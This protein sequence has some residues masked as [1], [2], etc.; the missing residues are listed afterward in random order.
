MASESRQ[1][2]ADGVHFVYFGD[3]MCSWCYG[4]A[5]IMKAVAQHFADRVPLKVVLGGLRAGNTQ[6]M[7]DQDRDY[8]RNAWTRVHEAS[9]QP[10]DFS[11][12]DRES[13]TYDTEPAC[14]AVVAMRHLAPE[15]TLEFKS[16]IS[17][18][19][20]ANGRDTTDGAVLCDIAEEAGHD[21]AA[22]KAHLADPDIRNETFR[23]FLFAQQSGVQGF[24]C[25]V[26]GTEDQGYALITSGFRPLDGL[27]EAIETWLKQSGQPTAAE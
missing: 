9:G 23:D 12:F 1:S 2:S 6:A 18:A 3:P 22:F 21:R 16:Q 20:Y 14:R 15:Q 17:T 4:F 11:F 7:R 8:I 25:L 13:F 5:P 10:F 26:I 24:P 27:I 19:F